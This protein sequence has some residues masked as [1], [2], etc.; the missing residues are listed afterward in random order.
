MNN[1]YLYNTE[2][3]WFALRVKSRCE[4]MVALMAHSRGFQEFLPV[5][6]CRNRWSDRE[7]EVVF[8]RLK[9]QQRLPLLMIPGVV[10][11][12]GIGKVPAPVDDAEVAALQAAVQSGL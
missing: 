12:V 2:E 4:K 8:C 1:E 7:Q 10:H 3:R 6:R 9:P 11:M 5:Y